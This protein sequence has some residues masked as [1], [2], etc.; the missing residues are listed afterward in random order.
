MADEARFIFVLQDE[1]GGAAPSGGPPAGRPGVNPR[2]ASRDAF[3]DAGGGA[4]GAADVGQE[5][6]APNRAPRMPAHHPTAKIA[7]PALP[8]MNAAERAATLV[9]GRGIGAAPALGA[10]AAGAIGVGAAVAVPATLIAGAVRHITKT[11]DE[12]A[13]FSPDIMGVRAASRAADAMEN[14][15]QARRYGA[16]LAEVETGRGMLWRETKGLGR[17][18]MGPAGENFGDMLQVMGGIMQM[19]KKGWEGFWDALEERIPED[20]PM[21][22]L[23]KGPWGNLRDKLVE[24]GLIEIP[25]AG[26]FSLFQWFRDEKFIDAGLKLEAGEVADPL[27]IHGAPAGLRLP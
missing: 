11:T 13:R 27:V 15:R 8:G 6:R 12:L 19:S 18:L 14:I 22:W 3:L 5:R 1:G 4:P 17:A 23:W 24:G 16:G 21:R 9:A 20:G 25:D 10:M 7:G 2:T 26:A